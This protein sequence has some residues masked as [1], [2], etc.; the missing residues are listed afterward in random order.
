MIRMRLSIAMSDL[1]H[2][3]ESDI[4][5]NKAFSTDSTDSQLS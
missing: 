1:A 2:I 3:P 4:S 5:F